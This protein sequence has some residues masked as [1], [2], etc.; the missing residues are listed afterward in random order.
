MKCWQAVKV[1][2]AV[3]SFSSQTI[4]VFMCVSGRQRANKFDKRKIQAS[5]GWLS[6]PGIPRGQK[7]AARSLTWLEVF[8]QMGQKRTIK[9]HFNKMCDVINVDSRSSSKQ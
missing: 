4:K 2:P 9:R 5:P 3:V 6:G 7:Q 1:V 8:S